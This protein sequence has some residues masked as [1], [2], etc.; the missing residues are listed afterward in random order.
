MPLR[1][2]PLPVAG[3]LRDGPQ[4]GHGVACQVLE[5]HAVLDRGDLEALVSGV[6]P[7]GQGQ[8]GLLAQLVLDLG[9]EINAVLV[10]T[11]LCGI[12]GAG[13]AAASVIWEM[14]DWSLVKQTGLYF[15]IS[16]LLMIP[17]AWL[18]NWME[19][20]FRGFVIYFGIFLIIFV[21]I[22]LI[23]YLFIR[24]NIK[25]MNAKITK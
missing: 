23:Q 17:V 20:S 2:D 12:L 21:I 24:E 14:E 7:H 4:V 11:L 9:N 13:F 8:L 3:V 6:Q 15:L 16:S 22:W 25:K 10:Q 18:A 19:H 1:L 5:P